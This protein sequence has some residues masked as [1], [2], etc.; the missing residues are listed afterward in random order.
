MNSVLLLILIIS[1]VL[2]KIILSANP[3][4]NDFELI[5]KDGNHNTIDIASQGDY[6]FA[7]KSDNKLYKWNSVTSQFDFFQ[8]PQILGVDIAV[9]SVTVT[10]QEVIWVCADSYNKLFKY[11]AGTWSQ[12]T[13]PYSCYIVRT[14]YGPNTKVVVGTEGTQSSTFYYQSSPGTFTSQA[15]ASNIYSFT[16][17]DTGKT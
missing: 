10:E 15:V 2:I 17:G 1:Q 5:L 7:V 6:T 4:I 12:I 14:G 8:G 9:R 3:Q 13:F 11:V 16:V